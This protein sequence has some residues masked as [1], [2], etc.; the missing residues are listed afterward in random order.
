MIKN[1][2]LDFGYSDK[3]SKYVG[4]PRVATTDL[5]TASVIDG[6][7][8]NEGGIVY[9]KNTKT[10]KFS[11]GSSWAAIDT[12]G[13]SSTAD[14]IYN[15]GAWTVTVD[16]NDVTFTL[17]TGYNLLVKSAATGTT[18]VAVEINDNTGGTIT[19]GILFTA[20]NSIVD[21]IDA[22]AAN[23]NNAINIGA[24][25]IA[26]TNF[27]VTGAGAVTAVGVNYGSGS[28]SG[29]GNIAIN[30]DKFTV[31]AASGNTVVAGTLAVTGNATF[32]GDVT[33]TGSLTYGG[34][35]TVGAT[36]TVDEL[37]LDTDGVA[38]AATNCYA[39]RDNSGDLTV[40]A[41]T[42][43]QFIV[44]INGTDEYTFSATVLDM[45]D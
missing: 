18:A 22:S 6:K 7:K 4:L 2:N 13:A 16:A 14:D 15:N 43:K 36:V 8:G 12:S 11:N 42:G 35:W 29:T 3:G 38:P 33:V 10:V 39:V 37:I 28:L 40:N 31:T 24:N 45:L 5:E 32:S 27:S 26:G 17:A 25:A 34:N 9:D 21:A 20:A 19:D 1:R 30:T 23:I 41:V 44:A